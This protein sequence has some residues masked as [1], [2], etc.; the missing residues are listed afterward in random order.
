MIVCWLTPSANVTVPL[1][2][3]SKS[4]PLAGLVPLPLTAH[5]TLLTPL[6]A[7]VRFT[8]KRNGVLPLLP[9]AFTASAT[10][11]CAMAMLTSSLKIVP[12]ALLAAGS[13]VLPLGDDSV[14]MKVLSA[15]S[16]VSPAPLTVMV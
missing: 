11:G 5:A 6:I 10:A 9:S 16:V 12:L 4:T 2:P 13:S 8:T 14:T 7:P 3:P 1:W 15:S